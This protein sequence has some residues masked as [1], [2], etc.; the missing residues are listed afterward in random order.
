MLSVL[1]RIIDIG[2]AALGAL[3]AAGLHAGGPVWLDDKESTLLAFNC[4]LMIMTFP[5]FGIYQSWR[6]KPVYD[7]LWRVTIAWLLVEG[8]GVLLTFSVHRA[9]TLS[10]LWL[11]YWA[12]C[13]IGLLLI[14]KTLI[15]RRSSSCAARV[16]ITR[17][18]RSSARRL[19]AVPDRADA[20]PPGGWLSPRVRLRRDGHGNR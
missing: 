16:S 5:S 19:R 10:R 2:M 6:G 14:T 15:T 7:L 4:V 17:P 3:L 12:V 18:W 20:Q 9:D 1:S 11:G 13:T 8:A